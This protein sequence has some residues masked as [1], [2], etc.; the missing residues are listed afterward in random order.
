MNKLEK[1]LT[2]R[3]SLVLDG[4]MGTM[5][6]AQGLEPGAP[7]ETLNVESPEKVRNVH[8]AYV[9]AG[10]DIIL[11]NSFGGTSFRLKLHNLQDS[12]IELNR[13]AARVARDVADATDRDIIVAGSMGPSGELL[14]PMGEMTYEACKEAFA[15]QAQGASRRRR[16][17][18]LD[19]NDERFR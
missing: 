11:T 16:R 17:R 15:D 14:V 10:S 5:L 12:V 8:Q 19:R 3:D 13:E 18:H 2:E 7:P 9:D 4:A 1:L 6:F